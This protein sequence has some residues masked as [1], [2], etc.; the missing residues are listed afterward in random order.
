MN[1]NQPIALLESTHSGKNR[2]ISISSQY[3]SFG[4]QHQLAA[5]NALD[6]SDN[7]NK[8]DPNIYMLL[9]QNVTANQ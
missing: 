2:I 7:Y 6:I 4:S 1:I 8:N 5:C 9:P 3:K